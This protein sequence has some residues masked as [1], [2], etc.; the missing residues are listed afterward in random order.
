M[1]LRQTKQLA[2][3]FAFLVL[4]AASRTFGQP[5]P[6]RIAAMGTMPDRSGWLELAGAPPQQF[7]P[8]YDLYPLEASENLS[9]WSPRALLLRTNSP[10]GPLRYIDSFSGSSRFYR[11][12][13]N[14]LP[15]PFLLTTGS[16]QVGTSSFLL[17]DPSRTNRYGIATNGSFMIT[18]W[19]PAPAQ[20]GRPA[21]YLEPKMAN[22]FGVLYGISS[23][24]MRAFCCPTYETMEVATNEAPYPV[25]LY[26]HGFRV[27]RQDNTAK[28]EELASHGYVVVA[29]DHADCLATVFPD[30]RLL[31]TQITDLSAALFTNDVADIEFVLTALTQ[32]NQTNP[33][34]Q[35]TFDLENVGTMGWSYGG[36]V[37]AQVSRIDDRV[38][39]TVLLEAYLQNAHDVAWLGL[40]KPFLGMYNATSAFTTPFDQATHDAYWM[41]LAATQHQHFADWLAWLYAPTQAGRNASLAMNACLVSFFDKYLKGKDNHLLD[42]PAATYPE[43]I[44]FASKP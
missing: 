44:D 37:A 1:Q 38:R 9:D 42:N 18:L 21:A 29:V 19:Y 34:F 27:G 35:G 8:Y 40:P 41:R 30:G 17:T 5:G 20:P 15:T 16:Y 36:G 12:F 6:H 2:L 39:A 10:V 4:S 28:C 31:T 13:T 26:S 11:T 43:V 32:M 25:V 23:V 33:L 24:V 14:C 7:N 3:V 22:S